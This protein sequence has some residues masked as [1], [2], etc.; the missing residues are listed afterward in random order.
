MENSDP[1]LKIK[2]ARRVRAPLVS[3]FTLSQITSEEILG[4]NDRR[5]LETVAK[6]RAILAPVK[7]GKLVITRVAAWDALLAS[8]ADGGCEAENDAEPVTSEAPT[9]AD[10]VLALLGRRRVL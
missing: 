2:R 7:L 5:Y 9:D 4:I 3:P 6:H 8:L 10:A 1:K